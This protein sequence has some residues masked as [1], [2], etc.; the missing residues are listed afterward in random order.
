MNSN[1]LARL[2]PTPAPS[3]SHE[4]DMREKEEVIRKIQPLHGKANRAG[5]FARDNYSYNHA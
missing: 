2:P 1:E 4:G 3:L 5:H